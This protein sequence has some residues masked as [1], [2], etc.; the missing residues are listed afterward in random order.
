MLSYYLTEEVFFTCLASYLR[1]HS[2]A[3][4]TSD[5]RL[6]RS[7]KITNGTLKHALSNNDNNDN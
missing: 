1:R 5:V 4:A 3:N 2:Y 7:V 6:P